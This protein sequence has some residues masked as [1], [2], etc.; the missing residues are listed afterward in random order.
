[1]RYLLTDI[2]SRYSTIGAAAG[3]IV[4]GVTEEAVVMKVSILGTRGV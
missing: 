1:M 2:P 4:A 3:S